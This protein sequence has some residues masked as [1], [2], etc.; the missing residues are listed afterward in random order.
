M[1]SYG[2]PVVRLMTI[3]LEVDGGPDVAGRVPERWRVAHEEILAPRRP[4]AIFRQEATYSDQNG[5]RRLHAAEQALGGMRGWLSPNG[6]GRNPTALFIRPSAFTA[7]QQYQ[8]LRVWRTPPTNITAWLEGAP[9]RDIVMVSWHMAF[10]SPHGREREAEELSA[11]ADKMKQGKHFIGG[12]DCNEYPVPVGE[13]VPPIDWTSPEITD[14]VHIVHRTTKGTDGSR[15]S[16]TALDETLHGCGLHDPAR[17]AYHTL[18][19]TRALDATAGHAAQGQGGGRRID[20]LYLDPWLITAVLEVTVVDT[21]GV[22]DHH[23]LEVVLSRAKAIEAL[24]RRVEPLP[25]MALTG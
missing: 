5:N 11:L 12:G 9:G 24:H 17:Y 16:C 14:R 25:P 22:S 23:A 8:H 19:Q 7:V 10:N 13:T 1:K 6:S 20:R 21:T 15:V 4:D 3:N 18:G 2:E